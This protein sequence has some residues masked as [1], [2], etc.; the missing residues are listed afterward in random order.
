MEAVV[1]LLG[2][3]RGTCMGDCVELVNMSLEDL[4]GVSSMVS[5]ELAVRGP[6][7][8]DL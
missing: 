5:A 4:F 7:A 8:V 1:R 3:I 6:T 2:V